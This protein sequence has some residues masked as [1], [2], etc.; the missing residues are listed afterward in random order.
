MFPGDPPYTLHMGPQPLCHRRGYT[1]RLRKCAHMY[2]HTPEEP[3]LPQPARNSWGTA[4]VIAALPA[5]HTAA[6]LLLKAAGGNPGSQAEEAEDGNVVRSEARRCAGFRSGH[7]GFFRVHAD[8][9]ALPGPPLSHHT[10]LPSVET[11]AHLGFLTAS[12]TMILPS[13]Q[14]GD[15]G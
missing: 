1:P 12:V 11:G 5:P 9:D 4:S 10:T 14:G 2:A 13:S 15:E 6:P 8:Q 7:L 3:D